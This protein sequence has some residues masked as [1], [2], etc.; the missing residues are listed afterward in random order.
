MPRSPVGLAKNTASTPARCAVVSIVWTSVALRQNSV[1]KSPLE[2]PMF[3]MTGSATLIEL[4]RNPV[5][6]V[7]TISFAGV[8]VGVGVGAGL[9][10]VVGDVVGELGVPPHAASQMSR[11]A[12][13]ISQ[14]RCDIEAP[15]LLRLYRWGSIQYYE[16]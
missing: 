11:T 10:G 15:W 2:T 8:P 13:R 3:R 14:F 6:C 4:C 5:V 1:S 7:T 12:G 16:E 9:G